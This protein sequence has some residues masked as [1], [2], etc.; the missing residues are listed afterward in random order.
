VRDDDR[1]SLRQLLSA[2]HSRTGPRYALIAASTEDP[3]GFQ[4][5]LTIAHCAFTYTTEPPAASDFTL[6]DGDA[7]D[8]H[9]AFGD[10]IVP[11]PEIEV[12]SVQC[13]IDTA[14]TT[15]TVLPPPRCAHPETNGTL[16]NVT[17]ALMTLLT[18]IDYARCPPCICDVDGNG[19]VAAT[20]ALRV[21]R[22]STGENLSLSCPECGSAS[23]SVHL[24]GAEA[25]PRSIRATRGP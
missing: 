17:D 13:P 25:T 7:R 20:D 16:P 14:I 18:S 5:P 19:V 15:T 8:A 2:R 22:S 10:R 12:E 6:L 4:G 11:A 21:L 3:L 24:H 23:V 9:R 1:R